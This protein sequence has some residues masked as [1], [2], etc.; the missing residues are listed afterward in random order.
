LATACISLNFSNLIPQPEQ[1]VDILAIAQQ[2]RGLEHDD[3]IMG[4]TEIAG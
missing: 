4:K 1:E 3:G 2:S